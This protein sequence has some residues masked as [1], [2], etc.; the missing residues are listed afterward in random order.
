GGEKGE[1]G[2]NVYY[3][4][5]MT[6]QNNSCIHYVIQTLFLPYHKTK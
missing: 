6:N 5:V 2:G 1:R 4:I 3:Q